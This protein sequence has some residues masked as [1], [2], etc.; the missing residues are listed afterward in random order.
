[1]LLVDL[2]PQSNLTIGCGLDPGD[3]RSTIYHV[4]TEP[5]QAA[6]S[7]VPLPQG[8][9]LLPANLDLALAEQ[10]FAGFYDRNDKLKDALAPPQSA[11]ATRSPAAYWSALR[12]SQPNTS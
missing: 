5:H 8:M 12:L 11:Y 1:M 3:E 6:V 10:R 7:V 2:D 4:M 9:A